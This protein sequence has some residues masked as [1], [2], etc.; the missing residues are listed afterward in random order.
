MTKHIR[1]RLIVQ[2]VDKAIEYYVTCLDA[3]PGAR[4]AEPSGLVVNAELTIG[5]SDLTLAQAYDGYRLH[6]PRDLG[7]SPLLLTLTVDDATAVGNAMV[8]AGGSV[9]VPIED[10]PYGK[11]QGRI[12]DP[13]GHLWVVSQPLET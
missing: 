1:P 2:D 5:E 12:E 7:G 9:I 6:S 13:F 3:K 4:H 8:D 11:R 10:R